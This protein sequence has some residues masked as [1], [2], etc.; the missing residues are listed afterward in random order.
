MLCAW[1]AQCW[2]GHFSNFLFTKSTHY[3][4]TK[5]RKKR[6]LPMGGWGGGGGGGG[7]RGGLYT[8]SADETV[9]FFV[10]ASAQRRENE[11]ELDE[12]EK[13]NLFNFSK[14][15]FILA[16]TYLGKLLERTSQ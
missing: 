4:C 6:G 10:D 2:G 11:A 1:A 12:T 9:S 15:D 16:R 3:T 5:Y 7:G 14:P 8:K 13:V